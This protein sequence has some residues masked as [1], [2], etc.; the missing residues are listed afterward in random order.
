MTRLLV[1]ACLIVKDEEAHLP[2]CLAALEKLRP[3][4]GRICVYDTG[5]RDATVELARAAG[6]VVTQG[7]WDDDFARAK[8]LVDAHREGKETLEALY[9]DWEAA[10]ERLAAA[11]ASLDG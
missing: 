7:Y 10:Q 2:R 11:S 4:L 9:R 6:C 3:L 5:S 8:P 1:D